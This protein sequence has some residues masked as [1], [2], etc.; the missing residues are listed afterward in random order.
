METNANDEKLVHAT[1]D[2][3]FTKTHSSDENI[4]KQPRNQENSSHTFCD[5]LK[6]P[7]SNTTDSIFK[8]PVTT[9]EPQRSRSASFTD[10]KDVP[11]PYVEPSWGGKPEK[12]YKLEV[13][14]SGVIL[15]TISLQEQSFHV[16]GRLPLCHISLAHPTVSRYH[17]VLQY[18][19]K[20]DDENFRG[21]YIY[22]LGSTHGTFWNGNRIKSNIYVRVRGGHMLRFGCSQRKFILQAPLDDV[23]EESL[24]TVSE[25]KVFEILLN[26]DRGIY[27]LIIFLTNKIILGDE[28]ARI[29]KIKVP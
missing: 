1:K 18:R 4:K 24:Y 14:K 12:N 6:I 5:S 8:K 27:S 13:L 17:A 16:V 2:D 29:G 26:K 3:K 7:D 11:F 20:D 28:N 21:L 9:T 15:E 10:E 22:D 25:L 19:K 23:E